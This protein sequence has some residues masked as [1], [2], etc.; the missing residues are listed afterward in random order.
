MRFAREQDLNPLRQAMP[1]VVE[2]V[3][4]TVRFGEEYL[5]CEVASGY[6]YELGLA[7]TTLEGYVYNYKRMRPGPFVDRCFIEIGRDGSGRHYIEMLFQE[8]EFDALHAVEPS[9]ETSAWKALH[10]VPVETGTWL[11]LYYGG[12][13]V[14]LT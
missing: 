13:G 11:P 7:G 6:Q 12:V 9:L 4:M 5:R 10:R 2:L 1:Y 3:D 8:N 14:P